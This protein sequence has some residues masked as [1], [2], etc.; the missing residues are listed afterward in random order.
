M[1]SQRK[2]TAW[3]FGIIN[4]LAA[5]LMSVAMVAI[6]CFAPVERTMGEVQRIFYV[7]VAV[8]WS[9]LA[10]LIVSAMMGAIY[11][12]RRDLAWDHWSQAAAELGWL[13]CALALIT[14]SLWARA[15]WGIW[16]TWDP[17]LTTTFILWLIYTGYFLVR[18]SFEDAHRQARMGAV[19]TIL[20]M[21]DL[22][23]V[24]MATRWFRGIHPV[25][26]GMEPA[27]RAVLIISLVGFTAVFGMLLLFRKN[28]LQQAQMISTWE[29]DFEIHADIF[30]K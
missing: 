19:L 21:L 8:A 26:P 11:L 2:N 6:F 7:H 24:F 27:M 25:S 9:G 22:P 23:L 16:W 12:F 18:N 17:R 28:Q 14:G 29:S 20:G 13:G 5:I 10:A 3:I 4:V 1:K 15:A 30:S